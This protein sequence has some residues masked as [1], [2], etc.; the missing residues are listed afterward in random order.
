M[1]T[2]P[3]SNQHTSFV[4]SDRTCQ[5]LMGPMGVMVPPVGAEFNAPPLF[6]FAERLSPGRQ[7][8][9]LP[10]WRRHADSSRRLWPRSPGNVKA[11]QIH[12]FVPGRHEV[13]DKLFL[14]IVTRIN[15]RDGSKLG[16]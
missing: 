13:I 8:G 11:I 5:I 10:P 3:V 6:E 9:T 4:W 16:V 7:G 2:S 14:C 15:L 1:S 12:H